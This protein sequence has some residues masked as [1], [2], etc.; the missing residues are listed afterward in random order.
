MPR[1]FISCVTAEFGAY[2]AEI[3]RMFRRADWDVKIQEEFRQV[4]ETTIQKLS[5][6]IRE[7]DAVIHLIGEGAGALADPSAVTG[8][9]QEHPDF[10]TEMRGVDDFHEVRI[11]YTQWELFLAVYH[12]KPIYVYQATQPVR[13]GQLTIASGG[14]RDWPVFQPSANDSEA[15]AAHHVRL[16]RLPRKVYPS[17]FRERSELYALF[18]GDFRQPLGINTHAVHQ[19]QKRFGSDKVNELRHLLRTKATRLLEE[20]FLLAACI[21]IT[22]AFPDIVS[23]RPVGD[24]LL[25][26]MLAERQSPQELPAL[27]KACQ[28][29]S[30]VL[31]L[32]TLAAALDSWLYQ[33][34]GTLH[35]SIDAVMGRCAEAFDLLDAGALP[36]PSLEIAWRRDDLE[37][38]EMIR[39]EGY[40]RW[41]RCRQQ[42]PF[43]NPGTANLVEAPTRLARQARC[44][45][46]FKYI[47]FAR[48]DIWVSSQELHHPW[49]YV[50]ASPRD[51]N[52][53]LLPWPV[54][55]RLRDRDVFRSAPKWA[56]DPLTRAT[57]ACH[58]KPGQAFPE[59]VSQHGAF[60]T[61]I[62]SPADDMDTI[63]QAVENASLGMWLRR[64]QPMEA[65][66]ACLSALELQ[67]LADLP[68]VT[69]NAKTR[70]G[71]DSAWSDLALLFDPPDWPTFEFAEDG[72]DLTAH[73][74]LLHALA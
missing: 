40:V 31:G 10:M 37:A 67:T 1:V 5:N 2:R 13:D 36:R 70:A 24:L 64:H 16:E 25:I 39:V 19:L 45:K 35:L 41:G 27:V 61:M 72:F 11:S 23:E 34:L 59:E 15:V 30:E 28:L 21:Q 44:T 60:F 17:T 6:Y 33:V 65:I 3:A 29:R 50:R 46:P 68:Q 7:C 48:L 38:A 51:S 49:E 54:V 42:I 58:L 9:L 43:D 14:D 32:D 26:D 69:H 74:S 62:G 22:G 73:Q 12:A 55:M 53:V 20:R 18:F 52:A 56:V 8:F 71:Q 66:D 63:Q 4:P 57:L 47:A